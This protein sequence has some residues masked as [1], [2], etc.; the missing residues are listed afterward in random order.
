ME[1]MIVARFD[2]DG[3]EFVSDDAYLWELETGE[4]DIHGCELCCVNI[5][6]QL[7]TEHELEEIIEYQ[8]IVREKLE[9][10]SDFSTEYEE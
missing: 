6:N 4:W 8:E 2:E 5:M 3:M 1:E 7:E 9:S 10:A